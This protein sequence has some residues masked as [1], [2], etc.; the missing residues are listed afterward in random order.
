MDVLGV[1]DGSFPTLACLQ[2]HRMIPFSPAERTWEGVPVLK[3]LIQPEMERPAMR[4]QIKT[5]DSRCDHRHPSCKSGRLPRSNGKYR[6]ATK[7]AIYNVQ[8][9]YTRWGAVFPGNEASIPMI[10]ITFP[11]FSA[12][13]VHPSVNLPFPP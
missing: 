13:S 10:Q 9:K 3:L 5:F 12:K 6:L 1:L 8:G 4:E 11:P 2:T 7:N